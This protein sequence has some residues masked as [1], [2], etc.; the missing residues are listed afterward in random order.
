[1]VGLGIYGCDDSEKPVNNGY[2]RSLVV[3]NFEQIFCRNGSL[4]GVIMNEYDSSTRTFGVEDATMPYR[5]FTS[6]TGVQ[7]D[8]HEV[9][10]A[11]YRVNGENCTVT[12]SGKLFPKDG[13]YAV[14]QIEIPSYPQVRKIR[15]IDVELLNDKN[16]VVTDA[17]TGVQN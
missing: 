11:S 2:N 4:G 16:E 15:L 9:Y 3:R 7:V 17:T 5:I 6:L 12:I 1:M 14:M 8:I 10:K 13:V